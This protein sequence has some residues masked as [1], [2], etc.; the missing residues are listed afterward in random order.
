[1]RVL[2]SFIPIIV[3]I[4]VS[5]YGYQKYDQLPVS[6]MIGVTYLT[7]MLALIVAGL[8]I[9]FSRSSVFFYVFLVLSANLI[10][11]FDWAGTDLAYGLLSALLPLLL[12]VLTVL[13][14]RGI[15]SV[16]AIPA[17]AILALAS[18]FAIIVAMISPAWAT[19]AILTDWVPAQYFDWTGQPQTVLI[20]SFATLYV[21]L[22]LCILNPTLHVC[23]GFGVLFML[24][25]QLHFG[26][27]HRSLNVF[28]SAAL[29]MCL[30][31]I[32]QE[33]WRMA[34]ID[35]LT[36]L[37]GRRALKEK[38]QK[39]SSSFTVAML[40]VDHFKRFNDTYGHDA[41]DAVLRMI[42]AKMQKISGGGLPYRYGGEEFSI[43][44]SGRHSKDCV[45][46][47][48]ALREEIAKK[49]FIIRREGR[50]DTDKGVN[51]GTNNTVTVTV[52]IGFA[53]SGGNGSSPWDVLKKADQ[54]LYR[55]KGKGRN[56]VSE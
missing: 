28:S 8:S 27:H 49:P 35:E 15:F 50:R 42:A 5:I 53:D 9:R 21:M 30:F 39:I 26:G 55:A 17:Y 40:D 2:K 3:L 19:Q 23:A 6:A 41:G 14:D 32:M 48:E 46:H 12:V 56:C 10:L 38:F 51:Q 1:M 52:S 37:P 22:T 31:A 16:K 20:V 45:R 43:V 54:A 29:L 13:P 44:F 33:T 25:V 36:G 4:I 47:L 7:H 18:A 34:Y 11:R 24:I